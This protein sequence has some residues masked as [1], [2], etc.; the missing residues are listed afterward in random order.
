MIEFIHTNAGGMAYIHFP[1]E[2]LT[3]ARVLHVKM[4]FHNWASTMW[5]SMGFYSTR[6]QKWE[7]DAA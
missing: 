2:S 1:W 4:N 3:E 6:L 5:L 7:R